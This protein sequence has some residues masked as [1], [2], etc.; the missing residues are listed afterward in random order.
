MIVF[1]L[2]DTL[3][4][5]FTYVDSGIRAVA[6]DAEEA[7]IMPASKA[8]DLVKNAP[9]TASGFDRLAAIALESETYELFDIQ[10]M[11]AVYRYHIPEITLPLES[12][13]LLD[14]LK[15]AGITL[16]LI[17]DGRSL[18]QRAKIRTLELDTYIPSE[19]ILI[20]GEIGSD[21][22][23]PTAYELMMKR[24]PSEKSFTYIG[25][26]PDKDFYWPNKLGWKTVMLR[27]T[28]CVNIHPQ[29]LSE[30]PGSQYEAQY[31]ID[32]L[33]DLLDIP[34]VRCDD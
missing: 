25:D 23:W 24:N 19:N 26:N 22:H 11:L 14:S 16:G 5:E 21:K 9:D 8:Y 33:S 17:T 20:S 32:S 13:Q 3:Y 18:S 6:A 2:D 10:R 27:D 34:G 30:I 1:D 12:R 7:G 15:T 4:K 31:T 28:D 29:R